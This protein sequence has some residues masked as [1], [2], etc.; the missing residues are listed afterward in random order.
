MKINQR[1]IDFPQR[2]QV[3]KTRTNVVATTDDRAEALAALRALSWTRYTEE[4]WIWDSEEGFRWYIQGED[5]VYVY[6]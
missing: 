2:Y 3:Y 4:P 1:P 6:P 5:Y